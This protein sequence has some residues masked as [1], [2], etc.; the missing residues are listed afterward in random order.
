MN[1][2]ITDEPVYNTHTHDYQGVGEM[3]RGHNFQTIAA[4]KCFDWK[5]TEYLAIIE[6]G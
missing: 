2:N 5:K 3:E 6:R 1:L 4:F